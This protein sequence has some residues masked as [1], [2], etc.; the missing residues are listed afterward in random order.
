[1]ICPSAPISVAH[2]SPSSIDP[3][4]PLLLTLLLHQHTPS[5]A[6]TLSSRNGPSLFGLLGK[7]QPGD[8]EKSNL[9]NFSVLCKIVEIASCSYKWVKICTQILK[10]WYKKTSWLQWFKQS[11]PPPPPHHHHHH[12]WF[13]HPLAIQIPNGASSH[14]SFFNFCGPRRH[15]SPPRRN[16]PRQGSQ[17]TWKKP[18]IHAL[19]LILRIKSPAS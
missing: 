17:K 16:L 12:Q 13:S 8:R 15:P 2:H 5:S 18:T 11:S 9:I 19:S 10:Y 4:D 6:F 14:S 7:I 3:P 1:M